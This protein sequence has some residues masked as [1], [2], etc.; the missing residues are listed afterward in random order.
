[1]ALNFFRLSSHLSI[2]KLGLIILIFMLQIIR[3]LG[4]NLEIV[5]QSHYLLN[6]LFFSLA[7]RAHNIWTNFIILVEIKASRKEY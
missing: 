1:M 3:S 2:F 4:Q 5:L 7:L 6:E